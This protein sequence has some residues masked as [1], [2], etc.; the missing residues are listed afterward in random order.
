MASTVIKYMVNLKAPDVSGLVGEEGDKSGSSAQTNDDEEARTA[1]QED[2][3]KRH[4]RNDEER[5]KMRDEIR[6]KVI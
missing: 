1:Q 4:K 2:I 5:E 6:K 3:T